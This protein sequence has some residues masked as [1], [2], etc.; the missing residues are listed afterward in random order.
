MAR[1][2]RHFAL[3]NRVAVVTGGAGGLGFGMAQALA[4]AGADIAILDVDK[5]R[6]ESAAERIRALGSK[7][8]AL[9][10]D[11]SDVAQVEQ[12]SAEAIESLGKVDILVCSA[13]VSL[14]KS[15]LET[16]EED[17]DHLMD[18]NVKGLFFC[19]QVIG[20]HMIG[21]KSGSIINISSQGAFSALDGRPVYCGSKAAVSQI[22]KTLAVDWIEFGVRVN[23]IAPGLMVTPLIEAA[24]FYREE[25]RIQR[26]LDRI[27][28]GRLGNPDDLAGVAIFLASDA[29]RY[30]VGQTI[31][32]DGG[33]TIY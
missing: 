5:A 16:T 3:T 14:R 10:A 12:A 11:V 28:A 18:V 30:V 25:G 22:S 4:D 32:V 23:A 26:C 1:L 17:F 2:D 27:P 21:R 9:A 29:S 6:A 8:I 13:G 7:A 20:R 31:I 15:A 24:P 19:N 33:W